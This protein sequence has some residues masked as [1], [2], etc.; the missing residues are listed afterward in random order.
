MVLQKSPEASVGHELED[1]TPHGVAREQTNEKLHI[2]S[3]LTNFPEL[4]R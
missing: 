2:I 4:A 1:S 3:L